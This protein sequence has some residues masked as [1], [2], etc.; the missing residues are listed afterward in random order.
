MGGSAKTKQ[1]SVSTYTPTPQAAGLYTD[2]IN[3]AQAAQSAYN[4]A[5]AQT[6]AGF[7][8]AQQQAFANIGT[9]QGI[10]SPN[11][12]Q[13]GQMV[14]D[15][16]GG[17]SAADISKFYNPFQADV[18]NATLQQIRDA[19]AL[20]TRGYM[21]NE[22][23]QGGLGGN[24]IFLGK[25]QLASDQAKNRNATLANLN[26]SGW[27]QAL[28]AAQADKTRGL[29]AGQ[30]LAGI[31][32][33][34]SQLS[35]SDAQQLLAAGNQQQQQQQNVN[36][37]ASQNALNE[38]L[39]PMQQA[40]WLAGIGA[41]IGPLTGGTTASSGTATQSQ[42]KGAGSILGAGLSLASMA[43]DER[44]KEDV[45]HV[46]QTHDGQPI[47]SFRYR[48]DPRTQMGLMAQD[49]ERGDHP[50]AVTE[51][52]GV[53]HVNYDEALE[54]AHGYAEGGIALP[55]GLMGW[56]Q[57]NPAR[58]TPPDAPNISAPQREEKFDPEAYM[59]MGKKA[60]AGLNKLFSGIGGPSPSSPAGGARAAA[61]LQGY[62]SSGGIGGA[63]ASF[64]K[65]FGF[66]DGG[67]I[68]T[69]EEMEAL[70]RVESGGRDI[71]N[72]KS[73]AFG[74]RQI[75]PA[76]ARDPGFGVRP[77]DPAGGIEDQRRFSND[78]Y[79]AMLNRYGGDR[80]AAR[81][82]YN[83]GPARADAW[84]KAGRDDSVI[85][86]ESADYYKKIENVLGGGAAS[87]V[88]KAKEP[89]ANG[90]GMGE[91]YAS[92]A[93]RASGGLLKRVFGVDFNPL[94]LDESERKALLVAGLT[95]MSTGDIGKGGLAGIQYLTGVQA[96]E[97]ERMTEAQKLAYQMKKD[98]DDLALRTRAENRMEGAEKRQGDQF[99]R[100]ETRL[101]GADKRAAEKEAADLA[102][103]EGEAARKAAELTQDQKEYAQ[104]VK[105]ETEAGRTPKSLMQYQID[106]KQAGR[107]QTNVSVSGERKGAEKM[108]ELHA[109]RYEAMQ[110]TATTAQGNLDMA[111]DFERAAEGLSQGALGQ[112]EQTLRRWGAAL[113]IGDSEKSSKGD[114][115]NAISNRLA[116]Q[117]RAPGGES[118]GMPGAMSDADREFLSKSVPS[119]LLGADANRAM[120]ATSRAIANRQIALA[121]LA[122]DYAI[123]HDGQL[124][125]GF[126]KVAR[127]YVR[128]HPLRA[129][130]EAA[131]KS[132]PAATSEPAKPAGRLKWSPEAGIQ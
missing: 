6:V 85:P 81:I 76:T 90:A 39:W 103:R 112:A 105:Q 101:E 75:M 131:M 17:I 26:S 59:E 44:V 80:E 10:W 52:G 42:G 32:Q 89:A 37:A 5:T 120:V 99:N 4:P 115:A 84:L 21:A 132:A 20:Q 16:G 98:A 23:A 35:A 33:L 113:G 126:D 15:A 28:A 30:T 1:N 116:M 73:G 24:G 87:L 110:N 124:D 67:Y 128:D 102:W 107:P 88:A 74:P 56:S 114:L 31:G 34:Q 125:V 12:T 118:G 129:E 48:G 104:Y 55:R 86:R 94:N 25:A 106:L 65:L 68:E 83:G 13:A 41:G 108:A 49:V 38:Q 3:Q 61:E 58:V 22:A 29:T 95:M 121:Q 117:L 71:V 119:L 111:N 122:T 79:R 63:L 127:E 97:R 53:K 14:S 93:D 8:P 36:N 91:P 62:G 50:E 47:Y 11:V 92:T 72:P 69:P 123:E 51:I 54:D 43:S 57:I 64:G 46:G 9:N 77:L 60:G 2:I 19:D 100:T 18:T 40:Q 27:Q 78:Y 130:V 96:G 45:R 82:A 66:A 7:T 109:K 70:E